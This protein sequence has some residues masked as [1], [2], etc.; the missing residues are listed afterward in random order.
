MADALSVEALGVLETAIAEILPV[1]VP[2][3]L[4][5]QV[6]VL[7][8][9]VR[10]LGMGGYV[11]RHVDP[12]ASL[13]G[14]RVDARIEVNVAGGNDSTAG[15]YVATLAGALLAQSRGELA[16][17]GIHRLHRVPTEGLRDLAFDI[18]F[19]FVKLPEAG[20]GVITDLIIEASPD[21]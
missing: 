11:G 13:F 6:R 16:E 4:N 15:G 3:G 2:A 18:D 7:A 21:G 12:T 5:R 9:R 19:E 20:E 8:R 17:R 10:P 14:R 1:P